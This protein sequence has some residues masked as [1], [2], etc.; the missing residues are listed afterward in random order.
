MFFNN[1]IPVVT[2]QMQLHFLRGCNND[3]K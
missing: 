3:S 1:W 2:E